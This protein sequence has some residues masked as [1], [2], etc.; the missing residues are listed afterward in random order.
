LA[1][2][3]YKNYYVLS[4]NHQDYFDLKSYYAPTDFYVDGKDLSAKRS[5]DDYLVLK[6]ID[7][8]PRWDGEP[9]L[10]FLGLVSTHAAGIKHEENRKFLPDKFSSRMSVEEFRGAFTNNYFNGV[11]QADLVIQH[12][13]E[14]L[15]RLGY[16]NEKTILVITSDHG[17]SMGENGIYGHVK[18]LNV[19]E[20]RIPLWIRNPYM[21]VKG[22]RPALQIDVA[23]TLITSL[24]IRPPK[25]WHGSSLDEIPGERI[26]EHFVQDLPHLQALIL[27]QPG[28]VQLMYLFDSKQGREQVFDLTTDPLGQSNVAKT[29]SKEQMEAFRDKL[30]RIGVSPS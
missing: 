17:E 22:N 2:L 6:G 26:S 12:S 16:L 25:T 10:V 20:L 11:L 28:S 7:K 15:D 8:L 30:R 14:K 27:S 9:A 3:G 13:M 23:P 4:S 1:D 21:T 19:S 5:A 18:S 29:L 24:G